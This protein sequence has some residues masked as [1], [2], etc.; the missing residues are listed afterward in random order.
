MYPQGPEQEDIWKRAGGDTTILINSV[1]R[2][3]QW[4]NAIEKLSLGGGGIDI[5]LD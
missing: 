1:S 5:T 4:Y 2:Q 3:S